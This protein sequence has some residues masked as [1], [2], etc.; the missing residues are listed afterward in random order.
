[1]E[2]HGAGEDGLFQIAALAHQI[3]HGVAVAGLRDILGDDRPLVQLR[4]DVVGGGADHFDAA[5]VGLVVG[6]R[7]GEGG[8]ERVMDVDYLIPVAPRE[9]LP[10][11]LHI[12]GEDDEIDALVFQQ[13]DD[14]LLGGGLILAGAT[15]HPMRI[16]E[17]GRCLGDGQL[18]CRWVPDLG[19][20]YGFPLFNY[21]PS[22]PYYA[23]DLL[24]RLG[25]SYLQAVSTLYLLGLVGA[26]LAMF[27]LTRRL[28]GDLGGLVSAVAY[29]YAPYLALDIYMRGALVELWALALA[30]A[31]LW[32][33]YE[34]ITSGRARY[35]PLVALFLALLLLSH[36]LVAVIVAPAVALWAAV[37]LISRGR[38]SWRPA[39]LG[40]AGALWGFGLAAFFTLPVLTEGDLVQL[41]SLT[42]GPFDYKNHFASVNDLFLL[43]TA[44]YSFLLGVPGGTPSQIGWFHWALAGLSLPAAALLWRGS[45]RLPALAIALLALFFA[46]GVYMTTSASESIWDTFDS[47][48]FVQ[49]PWRYMGLVSL[50]AAGLAGAWL[51]LLRDRPAAIHLLVAAALIGL[52]IGSGRF[53]FQPLHRC[54]V[55]AGRAIPCAGSDAEYFSSGPYAASEVGSILDYLPERVSVI[56]ERIAERAAVVD[57]SA[58]VR[59]TD[60]ASDS[61]SLRVDADTEATIQASIFDFPNWRVRIDGEAV[62]HTASAPHGLITFDLPE[63]THLVELKL[64]D[65]ATRRL[66]N[67]ISLAS[68][69][70]LL[71]VV[72]IALL[73]PRF[74]AWR[75][76]SEPGRPGD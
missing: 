5:L 24:H 64:E 50:A 46:S 67:S 66:A 30:P 3:G 28:W 7:A 68:W 57:G 75:R 17:L 29:V 31:L 39:L 40:G 47:L 44:D 32:A 72:P 59:V 13:R 74:V 55:E 56:P 25:L 45:K 70:A 2:V 53:Y 63:G 49:F 22:L 69:G 36:N 21:Y 26:G 11:H 16:F 35:V 65:T 33:V 6:P 18:P 73:T 37:L 10:N 52:L 19:N 43:R 71:L 9:L 23:G 41:D 54:T 1:M 60:A 27:A 48:R 42:R 34:L 38:D 51:A 12:A 15:L 62:R 4:R 61:L 20:G 8:Q 14:P 58:T 76:R